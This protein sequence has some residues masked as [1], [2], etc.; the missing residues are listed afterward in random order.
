MKNSLARNLSAIW[1][2]AFFLIGCDQLGEYERDIQKYSRTISIGADHAKLAQA[3]SNRGRAYAEKARY[4]YFRKVV[5]PEQYDQLFA[6]AVTDHDKAVELDPKNAEVYFGRGQSYYFRAAY[7]EIP[8][9]SAEISAS[10]KAREYFDLALADF[11]KAAELDPEYYLAFDMKGI[12]HMSVNNYDQA[13]ED[14]TQLMKL[15]AGYGR[16]RL[17]D[18]YCNRGSSYQ[19]QKQ[20]N[21]AILDYQKAVELYAQ[22]DGCSCEPFNP[23]ALIYAEKGEFAKSREIVSKAKKSRVGIDKDLIE[24]LSAEPR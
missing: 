23:L 8:L 16:S 7:V 12:I 19:R 14:F 18:V 10:S 1:F 15:K 22:A 6:M 17:A 5:S 11:T 4:S 13:I 21:E 3:Y 2:I 20:D 9:G 24:K